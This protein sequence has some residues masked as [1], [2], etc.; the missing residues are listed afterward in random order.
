MNAPNPKYDVVI[1][2]GGP[3]GLSAALYAGRDKLSTLIIEKGIMGGLITETEKIDNYPGFPEGL[4]GFDLTDKMHQQAAK[5]GVQELSAEVTAVE[6]SGKGFV[7]KTTDGDHAARAL[8]VA[9]GS[10]HQKLGI[11]GEKEYTGKGVAYCATC[12]APFYTDKIVAVAGGGNTALYE[13]MHLAKFA[14]KVY[15]IHRRGE[16]RATS[17]V[18]EQMKKITKIEPVLSTI[19]EA[20]EGGDFVENL[21]IKNV[22]SGKTSKLKVDGIFVAVGLKPNTGYLKELVELDKGGSIVVSDKMASS[23]PGIFAAGDI[24]HNSI[25]QVVAACGDGAVAAISA[26]KWLD[27]G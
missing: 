6:R 16:Y 5:Y 12:D 8:I 4:S 18:Q 3:A 10:T 1:I 27:E 23:L 17:A 2:G 24:R 7:V 13:A 25:Q 9:G 19:I 22:D 14:K 11:P 21:A 20:V 15:L 26:K